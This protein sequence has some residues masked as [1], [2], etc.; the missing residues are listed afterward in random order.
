MRVFEQDISLADMEKWQLAR[1][2]EQIAW[3]AAHC[4]FYR[5]LTGVRL[6]SLA[7]LSRLPFTTAADISERGE[8]MVCVPAASVQRIVSLH[9]S[10]TSGPWKRLQFT[11]DDLELTV[12]FFA[13]GMGYMCRPGDKVLICMP[14]VAEDGIGQLLARGLRRLGAVPVLAGPISDYEAA[15]SLL[16]QE[17]PHTIVGIPA[18]IR[19]LALTAPDAPPVNV[20]LSA[21]R[22]S[23]ALRR[24]V[25]RVWGCEVFEHYGLT[26]TGLG[27]AVECPAHQGMHLRHDA[28]YLEIV[29]PADGRPLPAGQWGEIV[30]STLTRQAMPLLRYR[31]GDRGRLLAGPC[32]CGCGLP[33]LDTVAGRYAELARPCSVYRLDDLLQGEDGILDY[34]ARL[35]GDTLQLEV[36]GDAELAARLA[37]ES[38]PELTVTARPGP[39]FVT[40]GTAKRQVL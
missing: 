10:G 36:A 15:A 18:Q 9:T 2:N 25:E 5:R 6:A 19:R 1:L 31:T 20:L 27:C 26:E 11:A 29:D 21:D 12:A 23:P 22:V 24:T 16:R 32:G 7:E 3:A 35:S 14:G 4:A 28:L 38:W 30:F 33:R 13:V 17:R 39:G 34:T 8:D 40:R 37:G